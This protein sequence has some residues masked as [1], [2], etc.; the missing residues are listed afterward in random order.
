M[1]NST[2]K[3]R[4]VEV[5]EEGSSLAARWYRCSRRQ[6]ESQSVGGTTIGSMT[7]DQLKCKLR[8]ESSAGGRPSK[9]AQLQ[10]FLIHNPADEASEVGSS[11][12]RVRCEPDRRRAFGSCGIPLEEEAIGF[13]KRAVF[14][15]K[16]R[17]CVNASADEGG[18]EEKQSEDR[19]KAVVLE[20]H[21]RH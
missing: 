7:C 19:K 9:R 5:E 8:L 2:A 14:E 12:A 20:D 6:E 13:G 15:A 10:R 3:N 16:A 4:S 11:N 18:G 21:H 17:S 1:S